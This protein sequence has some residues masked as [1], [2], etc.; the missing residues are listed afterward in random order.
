M[1]GCEMKRRRRQL[2]NALNIRIRSRTG[3]MASELA[4][5]LSGVAI[6]AM[7]MYIFD[8]KSGAKRRAA[9]RENVIHFANAVGDRMRREAEDFKK[10]T[11]KAHS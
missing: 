6:G 4:M 8:T 11:L 10:R 9:A 1:A 2:E 5:L 3:E 7:A